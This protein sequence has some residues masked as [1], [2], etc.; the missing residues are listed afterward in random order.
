MLTQ[1]QAAKLTATITV[2]EDAAV[3]QT[4]E[5]EAAVAQ[6]SYNN[7]KRIDKDVV[8]ISLISLALSVIKLDITP[9]TVPIK[10]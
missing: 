5:E 6:L 4:G 3:D 2:V 10:L 9:Q 7:E 8:E 1:I